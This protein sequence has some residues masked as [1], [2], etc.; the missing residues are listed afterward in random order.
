M[1]FF[2]FPE[3]ISFLASLELTRLSPVKVYAAAAARVPTII[4]G[5][6]YNIHRFYTDIE[7]RRLKNLHYK[8]TMDYVYT[9]E[10]VMD[11]EMCKNIIERFE[12]SPYRECGRTNSGL[13]LTIK[14]STDLYISCD[15]YISKDWRDV[16]ETVII[17]V[18]NGLT[19]YI[20]YAEENNICKNSTIGGLV[21]RSCIG[22]PQIQKTEVGGFYRWHDDAH[23]NRIFTY[24]I[25]MN[26]VEEGDGGTTD[27]LNGKSIRPEAG[28]MVIFPAT[29][30]YIHRG[31]KLEKG[32]KYIITNFVYD[33][34]P[35][36]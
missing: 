3:R 10:N 11:R 13:D 27:F 30:T 19:Q 16:I 15:E 36:L 12:N 8:C 24:I 32:E 29:W 21:R 34:P 4:A 28:K 35:K 25:Y 14:V 1:T 31:K 33:G 18:K 2:I 7:S 17:C 5:I 26:D 22:K 23:S 9:I 20:K 6:I